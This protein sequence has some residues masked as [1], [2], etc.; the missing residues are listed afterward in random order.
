MLHSH[1]QRFTL[2][3]MA[4]LSTTGVVAATDVSAENGFLKES[5]LDAVFRNYYWHQTGD[6]GHQRDWEQG[7]LLNYVSGFTPGIIGVGVDAFIY[8]NATLDSGSGRTGGPNV[9]AHDDGKPTN[10]YSKAGASLKLKASE[11]VITI[12]DLEPVTPVFAV[13][14]YYLLHQTATGYL[15]D[16]NEIDGV[17]LQAGHFTSGTG[18]LT[19]SRDGEL[20]LAYAGVNTPQV[21]IVGGVY[22][23]LP[24]LSFSLYGARYE[25][26]INQYYAN[27]NYAYSISDRQNL[28]TDL[29]IYRSLDAGS[30]KAGD[31]NVTA[32]S[33]STAY[34]INA[35]TFGVAYQ[36]IN[37]DEPFDYA[38]IGATNPG[39]AIGKYSSG[40]YLANSSEIS[41]FNGPHERSLNIRYG[42][43]MA[44]YGIPGLT[45]S[46]NGVWGEG[47]D[48]THVDAS[49]AY[50]NYYGRN[51]S[52]QE[53]VVSARYVFQESA[54]K[55][56]VITLVG[57]AHEGQ[58]S[59]A[60]SNKLLRLVV[61][62]PVSFF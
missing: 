34:T 62:Y 44:A 56:L 53:M 42:L 14:D 37:G 52:E 40:I 51:D 11:T 43:D 49:S 10:G 4:A 31:I 39:V 54:L 25:D 35:H 38:A 7:L 2:G 61:D 50:Y 59:T 58:Q 32:W 55:N 23:V 45:A 13:S 36:M 28:L 16:S 47:I 48:G 30:A 46:I 5:K 24:A 6:L 17:F 21:D 27:A 20:G 26:L 18:R 9:Q 57:A 41:D 3:L 8:S 15:L 19:T 12:G 29:N 60:G 33:V 22:R 1:S